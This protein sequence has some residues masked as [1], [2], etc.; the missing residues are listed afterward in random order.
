MTRDGTIRAAIKFICDA[1][2]YD[3]LIN[4]LL[5]IYTHTLLYVF[6][7]VVLTFKIIIHLKIM[8]F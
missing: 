6:L 8:I 2:Y 7:V 3:P 5:L 4:L 1:E